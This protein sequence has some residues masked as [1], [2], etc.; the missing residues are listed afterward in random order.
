MKAEKIRSKFSLRKKLVLTF[1]LMAL[2]PLVILSFFSIRTT[3][4]HLEKELTKQVRRSVDLSVDAIRDAELKVLSQVK[5][6]SKNED[7]LVDLS[8]DDEEAI[9]KFIEDNASIYDLSDLSLFRIDGSKVAQQSSS[10]LRAEEAKFQT[11]VQLPYSGISFFEGKFLVQ[12]LES[13]TIDDEP[14]AIL[15]GGK[16]LDANFLKKIKTISGADISFCVQ[17]QIVLTTLEENVAATMAQQIASSEQGLRKDLSKQTLWNMDILQESYVMSAR[18]LFGMQKEYLGHLLISVPKT[19][20]KLAGEEITRTILTVSLVVLLIAIFVGVLFSRGIVRPIQKLVDATKKIAGGNLNER[21]SVKTRDELEDLSNSFNAMAEDLGKSRKELVEAKEK[22]EEANEAKS[23][24]LA[25]MSHEIR[26]PMN[27]V[28]GMTALLL[29]TPLNNEQ[30]DCLETI[31]HSGD[32]LLAIINDILD[33]SKIEA[34]KLELENI[35]FNVHQTIEEVTDLLAERAHSKDLELLCFIEK[36]VP[37]RV[38]G[39]PNRLRQ[40]VT[41]LI[42]NSIKFTEKGEVV[43]AVQKE[44][45]DSF[46]VKLRFEIRDTGIGI[47]AKGK[48]KLFQSFSQVDSSTTRKFGGTG[49]GLAIT[50]QLSE[51]MCGQIGVDSEPGKGSVFWFTAIFD[52]DGVYQDEEDERTSLR[53]R[54]VLIVDDNA[55]NRKIVTAQTKSWGMIPEAV[56]SGKK[57]LEK[58][59]EARDQNRLYDLAILDMQMPEMDGVELTKRIKSDETLNQLKLVMLTSSA[60]KG[61]RQE[62]LR[63]GIQVVMTKPVRQS[64]LYDNL[65]SVMHGVPKEKTAAIQPFAASGAQNKILQRKDVKILLV[66]DNPVNQK[67]TLMQLEKLGYMA[68]VAVDGSKALESYNANPYDII[69]MDC[70]MPVMDGYETT[71]KIREKEGNSKHTP[72]IAMTANA[73]KGDREKCLEAGMDDYVSKPVRPDELGKALSKWS[74]KEK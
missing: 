63:S 22:A 61:H 30:R 43:V 3:R 37:K 48:N 51:M 66:E 54:K 67:V 17:G 52:L 50:K 69:L 64:S 12:S 27:G 56:E 39:D 32:A 15:R 23:S 35:V 60:G 68:D 44:S 9:K 21:V 38:K 46:H 41:N 40:M 24:F 55:T 42:G 26:T 57:A 47:D 62:A 73:L 1:I 4:D 10:I 58:I 7:L 20:T 19:P 72:I 18:P 34:G 6:L 45:L 14:T 59:Y 5:N 8:L 13:V 36:S 31:S 53:G 71:K 70:Q 33:F 16:R 28:I 65:A 11:E 2:F 49:L 74:L 25:N 29:D